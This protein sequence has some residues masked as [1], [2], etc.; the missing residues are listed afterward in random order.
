MSDVNVTT[1][2]TRVLVTVGERGPKGDT[3]DT[4]PQGATWYF[5]TGVPSDD[6]GSNDDFYLDSSTWNVYRKESGTWTLKGNLTSGDMTKAVYDTDDDGVVDAADEAASVPWTGVTDPPAT[7][8]PT[9]HDNTAHSETY[10]TASDVTFEALDDNSDVGTGA[11]QVAAGNHTHTGVYQSATAFQDWLDGGSFTRAS[12]TSF[13][14]TDNAT[15]QAI[16]IKGRPIRYRATAG[17]WVYGL[18]TDYSSG[19]VTVAGAP[20]TTDYDDEINYGDVSRV[21]EV[22]F[23]IPGEFAD[24]ANTGL[25]ASDAKTALSWGMKTAYL[26]RIGHKVGTDDSGANQ[27]RVTVSIAGSAV[28]TSNSNAGEAVAETWTYTTS[29]INISNYDVAFGEAIE[30]VTDENGSN[31]DASDLTVACFFVLG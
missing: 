9:S 2:E 23:Y 22:D 1:E 10:I 21:V 3:G 7:Y 17:T 15:N 11:D 25:L 27:P 5:G 20:M 8:A 29:G 31:D 4:G 6:N 13:T 19:T 24:A 30:V 18:V 16:Y 28:G 26:V 14:V 12:D